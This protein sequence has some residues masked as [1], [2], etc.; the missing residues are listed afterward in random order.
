MAKPKEDYIYHVTHKDECIH[1]VSKISPTSGVAVSTYV[2]TIQYQNFADLREED[3]RCNCMGFNQQKYDKRLHKHV[4]LVELA[5][6]ENH[7]WWKL[8][9]DNAPIK[10]AVPRGIKEPS[11]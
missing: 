1:T 10:L 3:V 11:L 9:K 5:L 8:S 2:V 4:R 7:M 6:H